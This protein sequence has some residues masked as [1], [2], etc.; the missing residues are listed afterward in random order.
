V[1][2]RETQQG[3]A[4]VAQLLQA[5][6]LADAEAA[7]NALL[8]ADR[9][10]PAAVH[11]L[12]MIAEQ[13]GDAAQAEQAMRRSIALDPGNGHFHLNLA[14]L[15]RRRGRLAEAEAALKAAVARMPQER[16]AHRLLAQTQGELGHHGAAEAECRVLLRLSDRDAGDWALLAWTLEGQQR[17]PEAEAAYRR[18]LALDPRHAMANHN[19]GALL[20]H[21]ERA[22]E[23]LSLL[24]RARHAGADGFELQFNRGRALTQL[25]RM[26]EAEAAFVQ[27]V[28]LR[29]ADIEAQVNLARLR[30]MRGDTD[31]ARQFAAAARTQ[32]DNAALQAA[33]ATVLK[34]AGRHEAAAAHLRGQLEALGPRPELRVALAQALLEAGQLQDAAAEAQAA[35]AVRPTSVAVSTL[36]LVQLSQ[37]RPDAALQQVGPM[38]QREPLDQ[39]WIAY[40]ATAERMLG[41]PRYRDLY[42]YDRVVQVY[43]L[44]PPPGWASMAQFNADLLGALARRHRITAHPLDQSLRHGSQTLRNL[45]AEQE[46]VIRAALAAFERPIADY[47]ARLGTSASHP[48]QARNAGGAALVGAWSVQLRRE[49]FHVNH[50]HPEGWISSAYY[51]DVPDEVADAIAKPG[52]LK[53]GEPRFPV[54]GA[55][56]ERYIQPRAGRLVLFPSYMWHGTNPFHAGAT[57]T[58]IAF[59]AL[60][61]AAHP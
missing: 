39:S 48:L 42:D 54:P 23:A 12:G 49:G 29:P 33:F 22:E 5:G 34:S 3:L 58:S 20:S 8:A 24:E 59:D 55:T 60:P 47:L 52:W 53:L 13:G 31:F 35:V 30:F 37:G 9:N 51:V 36:V 14:Q 27:A 45:L 6:R 17:L 25:Y 40:E 57:R 44:E 41:R 16:Q 7:C 38:R 43:D 11:L 18:A 2:G 19:L 61:R 26:E 15:L 46:P 28:T 4:A 32:P 21:R 1:N 50:L 10:L 56:P